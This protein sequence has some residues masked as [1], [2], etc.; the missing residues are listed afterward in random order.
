[1]R[2]TPLEPGQGIVEVNEKK[3]SLSKYT[4]IL[5]GV[6]RYDPIQMSCPTTK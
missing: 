4:D 3:Y 5:P 6:N 1:M 2:W